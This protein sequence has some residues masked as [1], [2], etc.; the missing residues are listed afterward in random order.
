MTGNST[1]RICEIWDLFI[2]SIDL[3]DIG[4]VLMQNSWFGTPAKSQ[5]LWILVIFLEEVLLKYIKI[6]IYI[7]SLKN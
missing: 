3:S 5:T 7:H 4:H 6:Y 1:L 2:S